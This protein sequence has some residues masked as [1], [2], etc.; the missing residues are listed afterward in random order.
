VNRIAI[1]TDS[2]AGLTPKI[3]ADYSISIVPLNINFVDGTSI[4]DLPGADKNQF[5]QNLVNLNRVPTTSTPTPEDFVSTYRG[6]LENHSGIVSI[7]L[8]EELSSTVNQARV[9]AGEIDETNQK[10]LVLDSRVAS[11]PQALLVIE[12]AKMAKAGK[13]LKQVAA[14]CTKAFSKVGVYQTAKDLSY[15]RKGGRIGRAQGFVAG[16]FDILPVLTLESGM[17]TGVK[18]V[19]GEKKLMKTIISLLKEEFDGKPLTV[20][21]VHAMAEREL[22][23][24]QALAQEELNCQETYF[25]E[26][27]M[28]ISSHTGPQTYGMAYLPQR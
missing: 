8:A 11:A 20:A 4:K 10:I 6:L 3:C 7:H 17:V 22:I 15:L 26:Q 12:A 23:L 9:A 25:F 1:V 28:V 19:R 2:A 27:T 16:V 13:S 21:F 14:T 24:L 18:K 5:Y